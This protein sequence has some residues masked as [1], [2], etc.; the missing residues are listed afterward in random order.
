MK[1]I[2]GIFSFVLFILSIS[3]CHRQTADDMMCDKIDSLNSLSY[4]WRYKDLSKSADFACRACSLASVYCPDNAEA[5]NN[6][7]FCEYMKM[8]SMKWSAL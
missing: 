5:L 6:M 1:K 7:G 3:A 4:H 8:D 2:I